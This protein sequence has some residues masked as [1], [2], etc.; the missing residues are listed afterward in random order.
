MRDAIIAETRAL[1]HPYC[2]V[3]DFVIAVALASTSCSVSSAAGGSVPAAD[4][5]AMRAFRDREMATSLTG[6][7]LIALLEGHGPEVAGCLA[8]DKELRAQAGDLLRRVLVIVKSSHGP[9][10]HRFDQAVI[11][12]ADGLLDELIARG[13]ASLRKGAEGVR[14]ELRAVE[15]KTVVEALRAPSGRPMV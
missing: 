6:Q 2:T 15:G 8:V 4:M 14:P 7:R 13:G 9:E 5:E 12:E 11:R 10:P 1:Y 3:C